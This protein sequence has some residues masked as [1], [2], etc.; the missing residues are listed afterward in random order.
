[1][2]TN[3]VGVM[4]TPRHATVRFSWVVANW[5]DRE[6][7]L[8]IELKDNRNKTGRGRK[9]WKFLEAMD[10][11][12]WVTILRPDLLCCLLHQKTRTNKSLMLMSKG[13]E[14]IPSIGKEQSMS[15]SIREYAK[16]NSVNS[17]IKVAAS[18]IL[19]SGETS[20]NES[21]CITT[22]WPCSKN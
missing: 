14:I 22:K 11:I 6:V 4:G 9:N 8:L 18:L 2:E 3:C 13:A 10:A 1:M 7:S 16:N 15:R 19:S 17:S 12:P 20:E 5:S 21:P